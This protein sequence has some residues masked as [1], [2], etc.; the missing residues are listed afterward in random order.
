MVPSNDDPVAMDIPRET[1]PTST[2]AGTLRHEKTVSLAALEGAFGTAFDGQGLAAS[3]ASLG[4]IP[5]HVTL[6]I[7]CGEMNPVK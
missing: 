2:V 6:P 5:A 1:Y 7:A 4:P 3:V